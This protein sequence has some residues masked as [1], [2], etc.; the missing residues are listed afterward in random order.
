MGVT[1][2][3]EAMDR[4]SELQAVI[5]DYLTYLSPQIATQDAQGSLLFRWTDTFGAINWRYQLY[6]V[7]R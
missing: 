3:G 1:Q 2:D 5:D 4:G 6:P 7:R